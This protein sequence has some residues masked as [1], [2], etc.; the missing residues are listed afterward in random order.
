MKNSKALKIF[1]I[2]SGLLLTFIGGATLLMPVEMK[3]G[4]GIDI[5]GNIN[6]L[7]DTRASSTLLLAFALLIILGAFVK[8]LTY[9][10]SLTSFLLFLSIGTGR[11][12]SILLDGTPVDGLVKAT[13]LEFVL[14]IIGIILFIR[15]REK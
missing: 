2:V 13:G 14:G 10:S 1:L 7:N 4:A 6:V 8:K 5:A 9:T 12:I 3:A 11:A 15:F